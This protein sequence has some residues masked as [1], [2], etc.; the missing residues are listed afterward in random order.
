MKKVFLFSLVFSLALTAAWS[1]SGSGFSLLVNP[2]LNIPLGPSLEDGTPF[3]SMGGG[4]SLKGEY[5][6]PFAPIVFTG[7]VLDLDLIPINGAQKSVTFISLGPELG[8]RFSPVPRITVKAFGY[9]GIYMGMVEAGTV[10]NPFFA[11]GLNV[12]FQLNPSLNLGIGGSYKQNLIPGG[13]IYQGAGINLGLQYNLG[14]GKKNADIEVTPELAPIFPVF[15]SYYDKNAVGTLTLKNNE[16][17]KI[18]KLK[19]SFFVKQYMDQPKLFAEVEEL[20][21]GEELDFPIYALFTDNIFSVT[22]G[23]KV[24]GEIMLE[25]EYIGKEM[26]DSRPVTVVIN[27]RNAMT[28]DDNRKAAAFVTA[29][30][31]LI[32]SFAKNI[33]ATISSEGQTAINEK[34]R[35]GMALFEA[36]S[37][38][39]LGY[40]VDP[41]S[42]YS[43]LSANKEALDYLQ[44]PNQTL[45]YKAGD[46]DDISILYSALLES[47]G[48]KTAFITVPGHIYMAFGLNL[49]PEKARKIF[50]RPDDL[51]FAEGDTWI[52]VEITL[53][54]QGFLKAWQIGAKEYR[55][56]SKNGQADFYPVHQAWEIYEPV[57]FS[58]GT[59]AVMLPDSERVKSEYN[60]ELNR[61]INNEVRPRA[62]KIKADISKSGGDLK[63]INKLGVLYA[64][65]GLISEAA[66][67]FEKILEA[68]E[69][70][71][72]L[73][74]LGNIHYLMGN[75][76]SSLDYYNRALKNSPENAVALLG[77][78]RASYEIE[79][80]KAVDSALAQLK[81]I[82]PETAGEYSYLASGMAQDN[83]GRASQALN[84]EVSEW[85]EE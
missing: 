61:F 51:V 64:R 19:L 16:R 45:A 80:Y 23:T 20:K 46:C 48:I 40:V 36:L 57:G 37:Y 9:G 53:V 11:A 31:P 33:A 6:L 69:F 32:L 70:T 43:E 82:A 50:L 56:N 83:T 68:G 84:K 3:Y 73:V 15:Y 42:S 4:L 66:A 26:S 67:E 2:A 28:W 77:L 72:A 54:K 62:D 5:V 30:D 29:K 85:D 75:S 59:V 13:T 78:A 12:Y 21:R 1:Q 34:F 25:Y 22:E 18:E 27:N 58:E 81:K 24:A 52:P 39:G 8:V 71:P 38:Y 74:N 49:Q 47:V 35:I 44:F 55:E 79:E 7:G 41:A 63:L 60:R 17:D 65:F 76:N 14:A 10:R